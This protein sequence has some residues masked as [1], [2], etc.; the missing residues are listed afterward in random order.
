M[1]SGNTVPYSFLFLYWN[2]SYFILERERGRDRETDRE[3]QT[4]R[5][6]ERH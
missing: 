6:T 3:R 5:Q 4:D 2:T 1:T